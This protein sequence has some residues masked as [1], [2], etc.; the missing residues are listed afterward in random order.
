MRRHDGLAWAVIA[1]ALLAPAAA[2]EL[3]PPRPVA[4]FLER[5]C[6]ACHSGKGAEAGF[7]LATLALEADSPAGDHR[8]TTL[9][10]RV[11]DGEMPPADADQP[12]PADRERFVTVA[13]GWL[14][15]AIRD[16]DTRLGRV[17][18]R[19]L[20]R[21]EMER[22]LHALL[23][24][25]IPLAQELPEEPRPGGFTTVAE[26][27]SLSHHQLQ[28]HLAAVDLALDEAFR[29]ALARP[30]ELRKDLD[31]AGIV[32]T[33]PASRCREPELLD[34]RAVVWSGGPIYYGRLPCTTAPA[35]GWYRFRVTASGLK[36]PATGG[37][38]CTVHTGLC[39]SSAP[40]LQYVTAFEAGEEPR[41][42]VFECW[43]PKGH[44]L[45]IRPGDVTLKRANFREGQVG[46]GEGEPQNVPGVALERLVMERF[47]QGPGDD[48]LR[49]LV[50]GD[51]PL[52]KDE[53]DKKTGRLRPRPKDAKA[54]AARLV[55]AFARRA[56]RRPVPDDAVAGYVTLV[57]DLLAEKAPFADALRAGYRA[58][59][60]SSQ[61]LY[62][63]EEPGPLD[64]HAIA[65]RLS[66]FVTGGPPDELL[67]TLA[68]EGKLRD[69]AVLRREAD[70]LLAG[71]GTR[72][73]V[74]DFAAEWLD[75][76][77]ID[78]T[79]P[80]RKLYP[81]FDAIVQAGMV[82]E[83]RATLAEALAENRSIGWL[84]A[85]DTTWLDSRL[86]RFY[87][88]PD[89][90]G[91][92]LERV[93]VAPASH[94]GGLLAQGAILKVTAN[95]NNTSP[96]V[97][98]V[99]IGERL[100]GDEIR[101]PPG[102]VPAI[103]PDI[104]GT[105]TIREQLAKHRSDASCNSCHRT[106]D[107]PG[108]ALENFDPAGQWRDHYLAFDKG[109]RKQGAEVDASDTLPDG[110][111]FR[112]FAEFRALVAA[113]P[114]RLARSLAGH[115]LVYGTGAELSYA[116]RE[117]VAAIAKAAA[118]QDHGVRSILH[119]VITSPTFTSK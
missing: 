30:D 10:D 75:L 23:G 93:T 9:I 46:A 68:D 91:D 70:R 103:E 47:H 107:P 94:R 64:D 21:R 15:D 98:G 48:A 85:A 89:V 92:A 87:D 41:E 18:G 106:I 105:T 20:T 69:P 109:K 115:L 60:C 67:S 33:N 6:A 88:V 2:G 73:F 45:E 95:G 50:F 51:L 83:T 118:K 43:L 66:Y 90:T 113:D 13:G 110:R 27:Q 25:D 79:E 111:R 3:S 11:A 100:L 97:R 119:A 4:S 17:D 82:A 62:L 114:D 57:H 39:V 8:W 40:L 38:W 102:G 32:R 71:E 35:D 29:R 77:Q 28:R 54:N 78:F 116:D 58:V 112:D 55:A 81:E 7:D 5:H 36:L 42:I 76:D 1:A 86:A 16:R 74:E 24:I 19:R 99:W 37:V 26:R 31:A 65:C 22:S 101:P 61:F 63:A 53:Q 117:T 84:I 12:K 104:R 108:F 59:L 14:T 34:E 49:R 96:V 72:R 80:D 56:F 44:M 52:E